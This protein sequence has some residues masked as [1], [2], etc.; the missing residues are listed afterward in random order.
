M[1]IIAKGTWNRT[2]VWLSK[3]LSQNSG[4]IITS[5]P[6]K[7][8]VKTCV[9]LQGDVKPRGSLIEQTCATVLCSHHYL[10]S[11]L[12]CCEDV[13]TIARGRKT[14]R[15]SDLVNLC[16]S[17]LVH[18]YLSCCLYCCEN[19]RIIAMGRETA[20]KSDWANLCHSIL[21]PSLPQF[22]PILLWRRVYYCKGTWNRTEIWLSKLLSQYSGPIITS[23]PAYLVV[24][25]CSLLLGDVK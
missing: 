10:S 9:L 2:E 13:C 6:A 22:M 19:V 5:L 15:S 16:H 4:P 3:P 21:V 12:Y 7:I 1:C 18:H 17:I 23:V 20:R 24:K 25:T 11:C 14:A 8:V